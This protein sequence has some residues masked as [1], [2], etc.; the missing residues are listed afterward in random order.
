MTEFCF[1]RRLG[2]AR[3]KQQRF[4][5]NDHL[6]AAVSYRGVDDHTTPGLVPIGAIAQ[7]HAHHSSG[8]TLVARPR[9][10]DTH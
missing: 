6:H 2:D 7:R 9:D 8:G 4:A 1:A 10:N 5:G 3:Q